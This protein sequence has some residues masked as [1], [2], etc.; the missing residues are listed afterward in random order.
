MVAYINS[1]TKEYPRYIGDLRLIDPNITEET[2]PFEWQPVP[3]QEPPSFDWKTQLAY[4]IEPIFENG[5]W[6]MQWAIR[7]LTEEE[8]KNR[9]VKYPYTGISPNNLNEAPGTA[10]N[11]I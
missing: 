10:P 3:Y 5:Q 2:I 7:D 6:I 8:I 11:V 9:D 4:E 1:K